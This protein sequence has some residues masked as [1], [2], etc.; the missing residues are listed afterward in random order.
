M[1]WDGLTQPTGMLLTRITNPNSASTTSV[2]EVLMMQKLAGEHSSTAT[3]PI[4]SR[5]R[6]SQNTK[7]ATVAAYISLYQW[8]SCEKAS[9]AFPEKCLKESNRVDNLQQIAEPSKSTCLHGDE[10]TWRLVPS[11][12]YQCY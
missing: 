3:P 9:K 1:V 5:T 6:C 10:I 4:D 12:F 8:Q 11:I 2:I 7:P